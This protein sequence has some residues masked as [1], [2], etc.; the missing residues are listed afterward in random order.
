M[1][2][3]SKMI[4]KRNHHIYKNGAV[5]EKTIDDNDVETVKIMDLDGNPIEEVVTNAE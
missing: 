5:V 4:F 1:K 2:R 3:V